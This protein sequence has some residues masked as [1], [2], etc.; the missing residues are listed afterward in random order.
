M[1]SCQPL[2]PVLWRPVY[3][4]ALRSKRMRPW[5]FSPSSSSTNTLSTKDHFYQLIMDNH[6]NDQLLDESTRK[7]PLTLTMMEN[8]SI[9]AI[10]THHLSI[11]DPGIT[12]SP[13]IFNMDIWC[14]IMAFLD[15]SSLPA[16]MHVF[17]THH[18]LAHLAKQLW[19]PLTYHHISHL[20]NSRTQTLNTSTPSRPHLCYMKRL[21][22]SNNFKLP[23]N[24]KQS[25]NSF[26][27]AQWWKF[28]HRYLKSLTYI[29]MDRE[30][31]LTDHVLKQGKIQFPSC[32]E[33]L[34]LPHNLRLTGDC[35]QYLPQTLRRLELEELSYVTGIQFGMLPRHLLHLTFRSHHDR[36]TSRHYRQLPPHL[37]SLHI[38]NRAP[39]LP[40]S[41]PARFVLAFVEAED[42]CVT[43][44]DVFLQVLPSTLTSLQ[45]PYLNVRAI[46]NNSQSKPHPHTLDYLPISLTALNVGT[47]WF[48]D[49]SFLSTLCTS[50]LGFKHLR[51]PLKQLHIFSIRPFG[52][53]EQQFYQALPSSLESLQIEEMSVESSSST[54]SPSLLPHTPSHSITTPLANSHNLPMLQKLSFPHDCGLSND[55]LIL[56]RHLTHLD[57]RNNPLLTA[58]IFTLLPHSLIYLNV[59]WMYGVALHHLSDLP[60][61]LS[62]LMIGNHQPELSI[63]SYWQAL[64]KLNYLELYQHDDANTQSIFNQTSLKYNF[65]IK[66]IHTVK[67]GRNTD[68]IY[69]SMDFYDDLTFMSSWIPRLV[70]Q[71]QARH[72]NNIFPSSFLSRDYLLKK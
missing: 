18:T 25:S 3:E 70:L 2:S 17:C 47:W 15:A 60:P 8:L 63:D 48:G 5:F 32:L 11:V 1:Q 19:I 34:I 43:Y 27:G 4:P 45:L 36:T 42:C 39:P 44:D 49:Q 13:W 69:D 29:H 21:Y 16:I 64:P 26:N 59:K 30:N 23:W 53:I 22:I 37:L 33:T 31:T 65:T 14:S 10:H 38:T 61:H 71:C 62:T 6:H 50:S 58:E 40:A 12:L 56:P 72:C 35:F 67:R 28:I 51:A 57:L 68:V 24:V 9:D 41:P 7:Q 54:T 52:R 55:T 46:H 66:A 20:L